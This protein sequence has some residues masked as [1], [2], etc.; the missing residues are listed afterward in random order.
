MA[1]SSTGGSLIRDAKLKQLYATMLECRMLAQHALRLRN[2]RRAFYSASLGQEAIA[3]GCVIDLQPEDTLMLAP[4]G[5]IAGLVKGAELSHLMGQI[6]APRGVEPGLAHN[7][8]SPSS[9][10]DEQLELANQFAQAG[11]Q[12]QNNGVV[13]AFAT[14]PAAAS[15]RWQKSLK[16]AARN[17]LPLIVVVENK[18]GIDLPLKA[19]RDGLTRIT[20]DGNDVVAVYRVAYES[21]ER[22]RQGGGPVLIEGRAWQQA[23]KRLR[24]GETDPLIHMERYLGARKLFSKRWKAELARQFSREI[25]SARKTARYLRASPR[26]AND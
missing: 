17:S 9:G 4:G 22:V 24:P 10:E 23:G 20:V 2:Q 11:K 8:F 12:K 25:A 7:I 14:A 19:P 21:L 26:V 13:V 6:Y 15:A 1:G 3:V 16:S 5:S 18:A